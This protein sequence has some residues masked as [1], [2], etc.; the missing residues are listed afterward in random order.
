MYIFVQ[1]W[2][3]VQAVWPHP[4]VSAAGRDGRDRVEPASVRHLRRVG[5]VRVLRLLR[6]PP[7]GDGQHRLLRPVSPADPPAQAEEEPQT[8]ETGETP[9]MGQTASTTNTKVY[10]YDLLL[11]K[12][13]CMF[14]IEFTWSW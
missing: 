11:Y 3:S 5:G 8:R 7:V 12:D 9:G 4:P 14:F 13:Y 2:S 1:V 6:L 10:Y